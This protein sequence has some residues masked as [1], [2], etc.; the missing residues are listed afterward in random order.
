VAGVTPADITLTS[1]A[2][3]AA[4]TV[5]PR[6]FGTWALAAQLSAHAVRRTNLTFTWSHVFH[7]APRNACFVF[8]RVVFTGSREAGDQKL[9]PIITSE[10]T[11]HHRSP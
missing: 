8:D 9:I 10:R 4:A 11:N 7:E 5:A 2:R 6:D 1:L 3:R